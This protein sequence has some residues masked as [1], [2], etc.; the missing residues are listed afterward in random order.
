MRDNGFKHLQ[1]PEQDDVVAEEAFT[2]RRG[3][4]GQNVAADNAIIEEV[5]CMNFSKAYLYYDLLICCF[6]LYEPGDWELF[7]ERLTDIDVMSASEAAPRL[8]A[9]IEFLS[10]KKTVL[11]CLTCV[12]KG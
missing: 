9:L 1:N 3:R 7:Q 10:K 4:I 11:T 5:T 6:C 12:I 2:R 8:P